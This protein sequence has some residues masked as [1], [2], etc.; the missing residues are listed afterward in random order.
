MPLK[1]T[2]EWHSVLG[3]TLGLVLNDQSVAI[4]E[5]AS[6]R[7]VNVEFDRRAVWKARGTAS[8]AGTATTAVNG[9]PMSV[10][11]S[12]SNLVV[13]T[14]T[15][16]YRYNSATDA[17]VDITDAGGPLTSDQDDAVDWCHI[18]DQLIITN[19][20]DQ[21]RT[22]SYTGLIGK[23][24]NTSAYRPKAIAPF[25]GRLCL[26][27]VIESGTANALRCRW[28]AVDAPTSWGGSAAGSADLEF[29]FLGGDSIQRA[30]LL[31]NVL[32][33]YGLDS[34]AVQTY[35]GRVTD[36]FAWSGA[37]TDVGLVAPRALLAV[38]DN[39][40]IF[41][42]KDD[43]YVYKGGR[44][45]EGIG[46]SIK[47]E[48]FDVISHEYKSRSFMTLTR[49]RELLRLFV[50]TLGSSSPDTYYELNV[51]TGVWSKGTRSYT[52]GGVWTRTST[53]TV[54]GLPGT[55]GALAGR[56]SDYA[57][58]RYAGRGIY[59]NSSGVLSEED[60]TTTT[61][62]GTAFISDWE[63]KDFS[64]GDH[65]G[66][67]TTW[68]DF[69]F[70]AFGTSVEVSYS[71]DGGS[72]WTLLEDVTLSAVWATYRLSFRVTSDMI[73]FRMRSDES[74]SHFAMRWFEVG[75]FTVQRRLG[76]ESVP[77]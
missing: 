61:L 60:I 62:N 34:I 9:T 56:I 10:I 13:V 45:V 53:I 12:N 40:H 38:D 21:M 33:L 75:F 66:D 57:G 39:T 26:F 35:L 69:N 52:C 8:F 16:V 48:L 30:L 4:D 7:C 59:G 47:D 70:E 28:S 3:P 65:V 68:L 72:T 67:Y 55:V 77:S 42:G 64:S 43:V 58:Q 18:S 51:K 74:T 19:N 14:T 27:N 5:R 15:K 32:V 17:M 49:E 2:E 24:T 6:P 71:V 46:T 76:A 54:D 31:G 22:W 50:P 1:S 41:L 44:T 29:S 73:R 20:T 36:P 25:G 23:L 63:T 11:Y 37:V